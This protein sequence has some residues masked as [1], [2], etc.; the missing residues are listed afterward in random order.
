M[1]SAGKELVRRLD[2][3]PEQVV[4]AFW[5]Y[6]TDANEWRL[7][8]GTPKAEVE[9]RRAVYESI[10]MALKQGEDIPELG[11]QNIVVVRP[12]DP[13]IRVLKKMIRTGP[14]INGIRF[15]RNQINNIYIEDAYI[16]TII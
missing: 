11:L 4:A 9:G 7:V 13:V 3:L 15:T 2:S 12:D 8:I 14:G 5:F 6:V 16:Y 10:Q 1:I